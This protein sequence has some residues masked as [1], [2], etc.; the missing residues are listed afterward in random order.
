VLT[1]KI[2]KGTFVTENVGKKSAPR[3]SCCRGGG[4][5]AAP[6]PVSRPAPRSI[7]GGPRGG[8]LIKR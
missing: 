7:N 1:E 6:K 2:N 8:G 3:P 4:G 5:K